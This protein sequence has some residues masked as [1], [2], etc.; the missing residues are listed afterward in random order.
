VRRLLVMLTAGLLAAALAAPASVAAAGSTYQV[1]GPNGHDDTATIQAGL[2]W[3]AKHGPGCTVQLQA[4]T[5]R[6][7]QL[8]EYGFRGTFKG[9]GANR[10]V[11][12]A[13][14][15]LTVTIPD[16][17]TDGE[18][19]PN[20]GTCLWPSLIV[21]VD[22][23]IRISDLAIREPWTGTET[24]TGWTMYEWNVT[25]M[26]DV[27][28]I[29]GRRHTDVAIDR[30]AITGAA[31]SSDGAFGYNVLNGVLFAGELPR[32]TTP[33]DYYPLSG[34]L[35]VRSSS[36]TSLGDG[37][38]ADGFL[39]SVNAIVGGP[40]AGNRFDDV[41][42]GIDL[43]SAQGSFFDVSNNTVSSWGIGVAISPWV[44]AFTPS[45]PSQYRI[46][47]NTIQING[48]YTY[49][50]ALFDNL[51]SKFIQATIRDNVIGLLGSPVEG[52]DITHTTG[53]VVTGNTITGH[54]EWDA[55]GLFDV[56][57]GTLTGNNVK[58]VSLDP[59]GSYGAQIYLGPS[60]SGGGPSSDNLVVCARHG[61]TVLDQGTDNRIVGCTSVAPTLTAV[62]ATP[63][64]PAPGVLSR[65]AAQPRH[66]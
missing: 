5:Y 25:A 16:F 33:F 47:D 40:A 32:S 58:G 36:F 8:V 57:R 10:T 56:S 1:P 18:C 45:S 3:C 50:I 17:A 22:G 11:I 26:V 35:S 29:M 12:E 38:S 31:D 51:D 27:L 64:V 60:G 61:D 21:F 49:G 66:P 30:V 65:K 34:S 39:T 9:A 24:T 59:N 23:S 63:L 7:S 19:Q 53:T 48:G 52:I 13:L 14:P 42:T 44:E 55:I 62:P 20:L 6:T 43:E 37:I 28:R 2:D 4:G 15:G 46:H 41:G 54:D